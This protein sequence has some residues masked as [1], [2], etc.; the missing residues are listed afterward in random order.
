MGIWSLRVD[1]RVA[2]RG[3]EEHVAPYN[4]SDTHENDFW[5]KLSAANIT[6]LGFTEG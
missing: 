5:D 4:L 3:F 6:A 1:M 2:D